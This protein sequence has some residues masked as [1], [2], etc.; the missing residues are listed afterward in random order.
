MAATSI[1]P[2]V[3]AMSGYT[4]VQPDCPV[5]LNQNECPF[6]VPEE[7]KREI[8]DEALASNW[9]RYPGFVPG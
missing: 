9:G 1:K 2:A 4:L 8:V 3:R 6:D 7:L 5:K